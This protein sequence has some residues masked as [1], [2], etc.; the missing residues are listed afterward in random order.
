MKRLYYKMKLRI[1]RIF[2]V[3]SE[4]DVLAYPLYCSDGFAIVEDDKFEGYLTRD[5]ISGEYKE[6][7]LFI[8]ML[9]THQIIKNP[10]YLYN[11]EHEIFE[12]TAYISFATSSEEFNLPDNYCLRSCE[13]ENLVALIYFI[14]V[15]KDE[16]LKEDIDEQLLTVKKDNYM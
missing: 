2:Q 13:N 7:E 4:Y 10:P 5:Y 11:G 14:S 12:K 8:E 3:I 9:Y 16:Y 15:V 6:N 1:G